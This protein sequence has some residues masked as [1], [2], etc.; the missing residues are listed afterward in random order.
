M[1]SKEC[2]ICYNFSENIHSLNCC[3]DK[4]ICSNCLKMLKRP[5]CPY[6]IRTLPDEMLIDN[7]AI[8]IGDINYTWNQFLSDE[9][10]IMED[11]L[12]EDSRRLRRRMRRLRYNYM[13]KV[14]KGQNQKYKRAVRRLKRRQIQNQMEEDIFDL[15]I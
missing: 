4:Y 5:V 1:M 3:I 12:Y 13:M 6:C 10:V 2:N 7:I 15:E 9:N 11:E 8:S 14:T